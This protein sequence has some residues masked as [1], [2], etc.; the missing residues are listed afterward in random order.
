MLLV[1][2]VAVTVSIYGVQLLLGI[3]DFHMTSEYPIDELILH[4]VMASNSKPCIKHIIDF[5]MI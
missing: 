5:I 2:T 3:N 1:L 4:A